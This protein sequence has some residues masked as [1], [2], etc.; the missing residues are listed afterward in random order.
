MQ[1]RGLLN[2]SDEATADRA[3]LIGCKGDSGVRNAEKP[4]LHPSTHLI[5][6]RKRIATLEQKH[7]A[8]NTPDSVSM[9]GTTSRATG[10][11]AGRRSPC[12]FIL[13]K[14][15]RVWR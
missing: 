4:S 9:V 6:S 14:G 15:P 12:T 2:P 13:M 3:R 1:T 5:P 11:V 10:F 7:L 8:Q